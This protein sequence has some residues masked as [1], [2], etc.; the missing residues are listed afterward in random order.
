MD[1]DEII[2]LKKPKLRGATAIAGS[3]GLRSVGSV[4]IDYLIERWKPELFA[5]LHSSSFPVLYHGVPYA[6]AT[7]E[8]GIKVQ[9]GMVDAP[10]IEFY[11]GKK[12][13]ITKGY[14]AEFSGQYKVARTVIDLYKELD[15]KRIIVLGGYV[16]RAQ[17]K[18]LSEKPRGVS[19]C[20]TTPKIVKEMEKLGLGS[21]YIG[22]FL[23][24]SALVLGVGMREGIEGI[25]LFG[26]TVP[27]FD[28]PTNPDPAAAT[29]VLE[30]LSLVLG[31]EIDTSGLFG[32]EEREK[33][34]KI[35]GYI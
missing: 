28:R 12:L 15:V 33:V 11:Q 2:Y 8:A 3:Q 27:D 34:E 26:E 17:D 18:P 14:Q 29:A 10:K 30:K 19:F 13:V 25:A 22:P 21:E 1:T 4:A 7:G 6:G 9:K 16:H 5:E 20:A 35:S 23:G 32:K 24:F 31:I